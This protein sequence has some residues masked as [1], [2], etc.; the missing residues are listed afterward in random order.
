MKRILCGLLS[1]WM[2]MSLAVTALADTGELTEGALGQ[3]SETAEDMVG[4]AGAGGMGLA[5]YSD[6]IAANV[7]HNKRYES[8]QKMLGIDVSE[9]QGRIDWAK[10]ASDGVE[11]AI[12]RLGGR[13][14][15]SGEFYEDDTV[16][17]NLAQARANGILVGAYYFSQAIT[18]E[19]AREEAAESLRI[20]GDFELDLPVFL[21]VEYVNNGGRLYE[22][23]LS[24]EE[25]TAICLAYCGAMAE[26]GLEAGVYAAFL[27]YPIHAKPLTDAGYYVWHAHWSQSTSLTAWYD[28]WQFSAT[29]HV[30]GIVGDVDLDYWYRPAPAS[31]FHDVLE[32]D[33]YHD[34]VVHVVNKGLFNGMGNNLFLPYSAMNREMFV[35]VLYRLAGSPA[36]SG[37]SDF[38]DVTNSDSWYYNAVLWATQNQIVNGMGDGSFGVGRALSREEMV[39]LLY[40]YAA[41]AGLD[42]TVE[43]EE[44]LAR[45]T[46]VGDIQSWAKEAMLWAVDKGIITGLSATSISPWTSSNR[47]QVAT[48]MQRV[49]T[50]PAAAPETDPTESPTP[51]EDPA[52]TETPNGT[53][54]PFSG[55]DPNATEDPAA[56]A[57]SE[58]TE[59]PGTSDHPES[60]DDPAADS[61][62]AND[63]IQPIQA[64]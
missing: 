59:D 55:D 48:V 50:V 62:P 36:V 47:A 13:R 22:A 58:T 31:G 54:D 34:A 37:S 28:Y 10:V 5:L 41:F 63:P 32:G 1:L 38:S 2:M 46:D 51:T 19:E 60:T 7:S 56:T 24:A 53:E 4:A 15:Q 26:A 9:F 6:G 20:L 40:R 39:T 61:E 27:G 45:F 18:E 52:A 42:R 21:D 14:S 12:V 44:A 33:W 11:F 8:Y 30:N 43:N 16:Q 3:Q 57:D 49:G 29:G 17:Y 23:D 25:Q 35:T 64:V